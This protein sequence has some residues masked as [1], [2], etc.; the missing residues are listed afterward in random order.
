MYKNNYE[1]FKDIAKTR[2]FILL[3]GI[4]FMFSILIVRLYDLQIVHGREHL[5]DIR[6][7]TMRTVPITAQRGNIYDRWG[8][9]LAENAVVYSLKMDLSVAVNNINDVL[10]NLI[11]TLNKD[12]E[13]YIDDFPMTKEKPYKFVFS[14]EGSENRW[15]TDMW[16]KEEQM[17]FSTDELLNF[18]KD[19]FQ[20]PPGL[21]PEEERAL[22]SI[23]AKLYMQRYK[24]YNAVT[25]A[26][27]IGYK[28]IA[29]VEEH[30]EKYPSV[31]IEADSERV[32]PQG[33]A[34][35]HILGYVGSMN[36]DELSE[37]E[38]YGYT[39]SDKIGKLGIEKTYELTLNGTDGKRLIE[40][41]ALGKR[42]SE[43]SVEVPVNGGDVFLTIDSNLQ[44]K[45]SKILEDNL[46]DVLIQNMGS[47]K[48]TVD[49]IL[50]SIEKTGI[51]PSET[52]EKLKNE[53]YSEIK[54]KIIS[55]ELS[56]N[57]INMDPCTGSVVVMNVETGELLAL[58]SYPQYDNN[59]L[60]N[61][62][63]NE[64]YKKLLNDP[65][66]PLINRPVMERKAPG[67]VLKMMS[68]VA[69][70]ETGTIS[71][72][73]I[74]Q[75]KGVYKDAGLPYAKCLIYSR[76]GATHGEVDVKK[77]IEVSCNYFFYELAHRFG[78]AEDGTT[79]NSIG[80][81]DEYME[82]FGLNDYSGIEIE[83]SKPKMASPEAKATAM[84][85][86]NAD[87]T[88]SQKKWMDGDSIRC[89][90]GQ[91]YNS[92]SAVN[93]A[94]YI[95]TLANGGTRYKTSLLM[96]TKE[97]T[98]DEIIY[99]SPIIEE[100]LNLKQETM[101][102]VKEGMYRV[103]HGNQGTL[104]NY[105]KEFPI[106]VAAKTGTA[107]EA[108]SR[109]SHSWFVGFAPYDQPQIA[110]VVMIPFGESSY[111]PSTKIAK[112]VIEEYFEMNSEPTASKMFTNTLAE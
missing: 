54:E 56:L 1:M 82:K 8:V 67:S 110:V 99:S 112:Q 11:R 63:N 60:V 75:D 86:Y 4:L 50:Q 66:T 20:I 6:I 25:V 16:L 93:I 71:E 81:L 104:R 72:N 52:I 35:S 28:T 84:E 30:Y 9:P 59:Q 53:P 5:A 105:F 61:Q 107:E 68:A 43:E 19:K 80:V 47:G 22:I 65:A 77:A 83:E 57:E 17:K 62:F 15:K 42:V 2:V 64:Y 32:Y 18:L 106:E 100:N 96:G 76:Y 102:T 55:G 31:Y 92:F 12:G 3:G 48:I 36:E 69:G 40:V 89:A 111:S 39:N 34:F 78:N 74:I 58:V 33:E 46:K 85:N 27:N 14:S 87:A 95:A 108:E 49:K 90:I 103:T 13:K 21:T 29:E 44:K 37:Y 51:V 73:T 24:K 109:P 101:D 41:D 94:K 88:Q 91:S 23:R 7:T 45:A 79:L 97:K 10:I 98:Q 26:S 70:L 38:K